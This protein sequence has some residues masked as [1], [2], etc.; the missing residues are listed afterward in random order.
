VGEFPELQGI[1]GG[2]LY[3]AEG[4]APRI[5]AAIAEHYRPVG[6]ADRIPATPLGCLLSLAD[7]LDTIHV[8]VA[9]GERPS[10]SKDPFALRRAAASILRI[11]LESRWPL[12]LRAV[13]AAASDDDATWAFLAER[14]AL[15]FLDRGFSTPEVRAVLQAGEGAAIRG[16][17]AD[18]ET[19]LLAVRG[20]RESAELHRM[21][22]LTKR[23][24]NIGPQAR[25]MIEG[26]T[27]WKPAPAWTDP[28][29]SGAAL[30]SEVDAAW[31][32]VEALAARGDYPA[33]VARLSGLANPVARFFEDVLVLDPK[34]KDATYHRAALLD[35][36]RALLT[37]SFDLTQLGGEATAAH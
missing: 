1:V 37:S 35:R 12:S 8:L 18:L 2:L 19:R 7:K 4:G 32:E 15:F 23:I 28:L 31:A 33:V 21:G 24:V 13:W 10:G 6:Q 3:Q 16:S 34:D 9:A 30:A 14:L 25:K 17:L 20:Q 26:W 27:D 22:E 36:L 5:A 11:L 29:P